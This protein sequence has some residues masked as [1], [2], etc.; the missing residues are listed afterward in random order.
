MSRRD[1]GVVPVNRSQSGAAN[2]EEEDPME[3]EL[4]D[5]AVWKRIQKNTFTR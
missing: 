5:D 4:A 3:K 2:N 1:S